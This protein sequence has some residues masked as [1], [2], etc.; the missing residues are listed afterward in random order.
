MSS[1]HFRT[2]LLLAILALVCTESSQTQTQP[3][4]DAVG[5]D[6]EPRTA[7]I[8]LVPQPPTILGAS[9]GQANTSPGDDS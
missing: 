1:V 9:S 7:S 2:K 4:P 8:S 6:T 5:P 3:R